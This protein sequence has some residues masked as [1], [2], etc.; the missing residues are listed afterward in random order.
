MKPVIIACSRAELISIWSARKVSI[1]AIASYNSFVLWCLHHDPGARLIP[2]IADAPE[3]LKAHICEINSNA[4]IQ[5]SELPY[6]R[7][8]SNPDDI[9]AL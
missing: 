6:L 2:I 7:T 5:A 1:K 9:G 4:F 8:P 3:P